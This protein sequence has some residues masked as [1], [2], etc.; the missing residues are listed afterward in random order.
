MDVY[1]VVRDSGSVIRWMNVTRYLNNRQDKD[2]RQVI[3]NSEVLDTPAVMRLRDRIL[4]Q[5][6]PR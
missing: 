5:T 6:K 1:L 4:A 3:F 2:S